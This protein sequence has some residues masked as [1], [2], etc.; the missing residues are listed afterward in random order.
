[1][2]LRLEDAGGEQQMAAADMCWKTYDVGVVRCCP[3]VAVALYIFVSPPLY[4]ATGRNLSAVS[5]FTEVF[6]S[7]AEV[8]SSCLRSGYW[9]QQRLK[10]FWG[11]CHDEA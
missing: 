3:E 4:L 10:S 5:L 9:M 1:M 2:L 8:W 6:G 7:V 11:C